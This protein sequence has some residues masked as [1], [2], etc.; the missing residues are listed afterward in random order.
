MSEAKKAVNVKDVAKLA[1]V[2]LASVDRVIHN[3]PGVSKKTQEK[4]NKAINKLN[5]QPNILASN[6]SKKKAYVF[7]VLL[8]RA[9]VNS[10]YWSLP[11]KGVKKAQ[12]ELN[13]YNITIKTHLFE[14]GD[15][16]EVR[17]Q[18]LKIINSKIDG[19]V[20]TPK[21]ASETDILLQDCKHK[22]IPYVF[23][24]SNIQKKES[25]CNIEHPLYESGQLAAQL[26][27]FTFQEGK[28][29]ILHFKDTMDSDYIVNTK[30][31]GAIDFLKEIKSN[32]TIKKIVIDKFTTNNVTTIINK[33][34]IQNPETKG[35]FI[36]NS[37]IRLIAQYFENNNKNKVYLIGYDLLEE[38]SQ[39]LEKGI[40]DF[41][42]CQKP[43]WQG[44]K[45]IHKLFKH[46]VLKKNVNNKV[47]VPLD[48]I[49]QKNYKYY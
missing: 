14:Q 31:K 26:F 19:L 38:N 15:K 12:A 25:L 4:V 30:V 46:I 24:D 16:N 20:L 29:L 39:Y 8:P 7:A 21:F 44:Y 18:I 41:L 6:L 49:T 34:L 11:L 9:A 40:I 32:I 10:S 43:E 22:N 2:S 48:I 28:I 36:P 1:K 33:I 47:I 42:I 13:Q 5:Y 17:T 27:N 37:K 35:V 23:I 3:R 45:A